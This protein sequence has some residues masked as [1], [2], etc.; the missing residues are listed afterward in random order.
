MAVKEIFTVLT[1]RMNDNPKH[2]EG[3]NV[4]YTFNLSGEEA[5][6]Y[7]L[8]IKE[9]QAEYAAE[10][11]EESDITFEMKDK[12]FLKLTEGSLNPTMAYMSGKLKVRG[13]LSHALKLQT[14]LKHYA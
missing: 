1:T 3:M 11:V 9:K 14:L 6:V 7:Q 12:D 2:L 13:D 5:G 10:A 4:R 8:Q